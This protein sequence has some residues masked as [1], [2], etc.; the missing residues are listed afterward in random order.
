MKSSKLLSLASILGLCSAASAGTVAV[1]NGKKP[2]LSPSVASPWDV[3]LA[4]GLGLTQGNSDTLA[5][6]A[7]FLA[8]YVTPANEFTFAAD[9]VYG[10]SDSVV[11]QNR[12]SLF[13]GMNYNLSPELYLGLGANFRYDEI[14]DLDYRFGLG[15]VLGY[16]LINQDATKLAVEAGLGYV[17]E[18]QGG[19]KSDYVTFNAAERFTH[20]LSSG[21]K[22][23]QSVTFSS[24]LEDFE[25]FLLTADLFLEV[26][27]SAHWAFRASVGTAYD[28]TP[29][30]GTEENN[31]F[32][33]AGL[34]YSAQGFAPPAPASRPTLFQKRVAA[35]APATGWQ[36]IA[37]A[38]FA[39]SNGNSDTLLAT[40]SYD[41]VYREAD[42]EILLGL[43]GAYGEVDTA[44]TQQ[45]ARANAQYNRVF[46][47]S[48]FGGIA[49]GITHDTTAGVDYRFTPTAV[50][51]AYLVKTDT[52]KVSVEAGPAYVF[53]KTGDGSD[54][55]FALYSAQKASLTLSDSVS[56]GESVT[57]IPDVSKFDSYILSANVFVDFYFADHLALRAAVTNTYD[58]TPVKGQDKSDL[59]LS[60]GIA[61]QF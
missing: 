53:E 41:A 24:E 38:G 8:T 27:F 40:A 12:L 4:S 11:N 28:N 2:V 18:K 23:G 7:Q 48:L 9:Y 39:L 59:M 16:R 49:A 45:N 60:T 1:G 22:I 47:G 15:P 21:A 37:S 36:Q 50:L 56:I 51:G 3:S 32:A 14:A 35:A 30:A 54:S 33:L 44:V 42:N 57:F 31:L 19:V 34:S 61:I 46:G 20:T 55:Y 52:A 13:S 58:S 10:E 17:F 6:G 26:P 29:A 43:G 5:V 25:N